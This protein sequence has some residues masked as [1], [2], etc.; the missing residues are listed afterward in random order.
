MWRGCLSA[1][2][3]LQ[4]GVRVFVMCGSVVGCSSD[5]VSDS[6]LGAVLKDALLS[7][8]H[9]QSEALTALGAL[10]TVY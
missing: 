10:P 8:E 3:L 9:V 4:V 2:V 1:C 7:S 6:L 5:S